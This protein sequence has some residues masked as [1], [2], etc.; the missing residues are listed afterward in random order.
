MILDF[1]FQ[2]SFVCSYQTYFCKSVKSEIIN[3]KSAIVNA[4]TNPDL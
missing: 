2:L 4:T 1:G 3:L